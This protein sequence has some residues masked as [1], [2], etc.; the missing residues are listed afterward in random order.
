[1]NNREIIEKAAMTLSDLASGGL[2]NAAQSATF[3]RMVQDEP[4]LLKQA[5]F[6]PM[7]SDSRK[8]EK[9]GFGQRVLRPGVEGKALEDKDRSVPTTSTINLNAKEVIAEINI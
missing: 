3:L 6:V 9:I 5:R 4:T 8:I 2:M 1:M 7:T